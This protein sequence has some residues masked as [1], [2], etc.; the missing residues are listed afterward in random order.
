MVECQQ[1]ASVPP[2]WVTTLAALLTPTIAIIAVY[3]G[4]QQW[5]TNRN[6]LKLDLFDRRFTVYD[7]A[8]TLIGRVLTQSHAKNDQILEFLTGTREARF[9]LDKQIAEYLFKEFHLKAILLLT[10]HSELEGSP[11]GTERTKNIEHRREVR[12]WFEQQYDVLD[13]KFSK[14]I[15]LE[16]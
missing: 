12:N 11:G 6:K 5:R 16:H 13:E 9:L 3:I 1:L 10:L 14:Y 15:Q 2:I 8:R 7:A 4:W